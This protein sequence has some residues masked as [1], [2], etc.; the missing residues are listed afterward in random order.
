MWGRLTVG[1]EYDDV[2]WEDRV[3]GLLDRDD[4]RTAHWSANPHH[5]LFPTTNNCHT[6]TTC[7]SRHPTMTPLNQIGTGPPPSALSFTLLVVLL[8]TLLLL[9]AL[10]L[11]GQVEQ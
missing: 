7:L 8:L 4:I 5:P 9:V 1:T 3:K 10:E 2:V 6:L 11:R